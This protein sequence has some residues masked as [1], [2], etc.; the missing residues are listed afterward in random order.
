MADPKK[1]PLI[2]A[3]RSPVPGPVPSDPAEKDPKLANQPPAADPKAVQTVGTPRRPS[4]A[5]R[6]EKKPSRRKRL[7]ILRPRPPSE[8]AGGIPKG[9]R[10]QG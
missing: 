7:G 1:N 3:F 6:R 4:L 10:P 8:E 9:R 2:G 5:R